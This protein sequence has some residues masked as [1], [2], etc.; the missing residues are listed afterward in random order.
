[1]EVIKIQ[2]RFNPDKIW[3]LRRYTS[4]NYYVNQEIKGQRMYNKDRRMT[5]KFLKSIGVL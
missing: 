2:D 1:M 5:A 3:V 4:G